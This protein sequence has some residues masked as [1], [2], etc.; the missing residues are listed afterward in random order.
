M[1]LLAM[2]SQQPWAAGARGFLKGA[3]TP[4]ESAMTAAGNS[5]AQLTGGWGDSSGLRTENARLKA[6]NAELQKEVAQLQAQGL[7]NQALRQALD[8]ERTYGH[9]MLAAQV[10]GRG[11]DGFSIT[12]EIDRGSSDGLRPGMVVVSGAGLVGRIIETG[13][14]AAIV[15]TLADPQSRVSAFLSSSAL[16]GTVAGGPQSLS[17]AINP[18]FGIAPAD[19]EWAITSGVGGGYPR[20]LVIGLVTSVTHK[21]TATTDSASLLWVNDPT[22]LSVVLVIK[23]FTPA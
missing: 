13:P 4:F 8:F 14:H 12:L 11:P 6:Q 1:L 21:D 23:D 20:G 19:G 2:V 7:D 22:V 17:M 10:V 9:S 16:E 5:V 18:R 3:L 15:E